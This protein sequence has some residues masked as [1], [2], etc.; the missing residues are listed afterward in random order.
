AA[1]LASASAGSP[2]DISGESHGTLQIT[3]YNPSTGV[4]SYTY[5]PAGSNQDH[6]GGEVEEALAV[7]VTDNAGAT[8]ND[9]LNILI[10][11]T[12][13]TAVDDS[14]SVGEDTV[15]IIGSIKGNDTDGADPASITGAAVGSSAGPVADNISA[16]G[17]VNLMGQFGLLAITSTGGYLYYPNAAAQALKPG[18]TRID[19]F[20]YTVKDNDGDSDSAVL[21][22]SVIGASEGNPTVTVT[23]NNGPSTT[24]DESVAED[25]AGSFSGSFS[26]SA[27]DGLAS[28][29]VGDTTFTAA[30]LASASAGSPLEVTGE[31]YGTMLITG[32]NAGTGAVTYTY[33]PTGSNQDHSGGEVEEALA[34][35]VTDSVGAT[36]SDTLNILI[37]DTAPTA[38]DDERSVDEDAVFVSGSIK[39][40]DTDGADPATIT[41]AALGNS[42]GPVP[43]NIS[44]GGY[45][46]LNGEY[47]LLAITSTGGYL[48]YPNE[49]ARALNSGEIGI[50]EFTYKVKDSDG[51][52]DTAVLKISVVGED[53]GAPPV[54]GANHE[55]DIF[56]DDIVVKKLATGW[57]DAVD[58]AGRLSYPAANPTDQNG[59]ANNG[60]ID[61]VN[62]DGDVWMDQIRWGTPVTAG[63]RSGYVV[64]EVDALTSDAGQQV[65]PNTDIQFATFTHLNFPSRSGND[66]LASV[67]MVVQAT[68]VINGAEV[69]VQFYIQMTHEETSNIEGNPVASRDIITLPS[70]VITVNV[71]NQQY[72][73]RIA[74][75]LDSSGNAV[76]KIY[77]NENAV[78]NFTAVARIVP[79]ESSLPSVDGQIVLNTPPNQ[80]ATVTWSK[81]GDIG[82]GTFTG[83]ADGSYTFTVDSDY[84]SAAAA[85]DADSVSVDFT[86][87]YSDGSTR[88]NT[89]TINLRGKQVVAG[90][91]G[92]DNPLN[93]TS[94]ADAIIADSGNDN[95]FAGDGDDSIYGN[96]GNDLLR[97]EVGNDRIFGGQGDDDL[98]GGLGNDYLDGG[99][100]SDQ[101][102][103]HGGADTFVLYNR[104]PG[105][106]AVD[107]VKDF[108]ASEGDVLDFSDLLVRGQASLLDGYLHFEQAGNDIII[109]VNRDGDYTSDTLETAKDEYTVRIRDADAIFQGATDQEILQDLLNGGHLDTV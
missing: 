79:K 93:G 84:R 61:G 74:G 13:P 83:N 109:H 3:G 80:S 106:G 97:G 38:V 63:R 8:A 54:Q 37:T 41:G 14:D 101:L 59:P 82:P 81:S 86:V 24:G 31:T 71:A 29:K 72:D 47:G 36:A 16:G 51:D 56:V 104:T 40:N 87:N 27:P 44:A 19:Q 7:T 67:K 32:Y 76:T 103:G 69:P 48:Y 18:E 6:S 100:G 28:L 57:V 9:T 4:I 25:I 17:S 1:Q 108:D 42:A 12:A 68:V 52:S 65:Q 46:S 2:L 10:T 21:T 85:G 26:V 35:T 49:K 23:D 30:Q 5:D 11:D 22:I 77:T 15:F 20:T 98:R 88:T 66:L 89:V 92:N 64:D 70:E 34:I 39:G 58:E 95:V 43:D 75:L 99:V 78:N 45:L 53:D 102:E 33:D 96:Q 73:I 55:I 60:R 90:S 62:N 50:D 94:D 105:S 91:D 107:V